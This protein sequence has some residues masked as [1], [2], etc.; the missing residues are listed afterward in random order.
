MFLELRRLLAH[1]IHDGTRST[2]T[3]SFDVLAPAA[4]ALEEILTAIQNGQF[5]PD[6][7]RS[8]QFRGKPS[9]TAFCILCKPGPTLGAASPEPNT[10]N[11]KPKSQTLSPGLGLL[12]FRV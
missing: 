4:R 8:Q 3:C 2:E 6:A 1:H 12:G 7:M 9:A 10:R 11:P 5:L